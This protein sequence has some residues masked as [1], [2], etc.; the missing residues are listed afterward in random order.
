MNNKSGKTS[1]RIG[2]KKPVQAQLVSKKVL[3]V[4]GR[5]K[6][7]CRGKTELFN[8]TAPIKFF[9]NIDEKGRESA[10][11]EVGATRHQLR[12]GSSENSKKSNN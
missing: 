6:S 10:C 8:Q 5:A 1:V 9:S 3:K 4:A 12:D 7:A 2:G 11:K